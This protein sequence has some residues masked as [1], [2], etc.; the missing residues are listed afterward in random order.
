MEAFCRRKWKLSIYPK[1]E[2]LYT[3]METI[4]TIGNSLYANENYIRT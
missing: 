1:M 2:T 3:Q 4:Y